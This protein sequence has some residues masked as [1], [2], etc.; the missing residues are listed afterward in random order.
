MNKFFPRAPE[1]PIRTI[2]KNLRRYWRKNVCQRCQRPSDKREKSLSIIFLNILYNYILYIGSI[3]LFPVSLSTKQV[4]KFISGVVDLGEQ[5][6]G[7]AVD[8]GNKF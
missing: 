1:Y 7:D 2:F 5:F 6:F 4:K 3:V 8:T